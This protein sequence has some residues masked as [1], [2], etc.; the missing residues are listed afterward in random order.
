[1]GWEHGRHMK[2]S[3]IFLLNITCREWYLAVLCPLFSWISSKFW[4]FPVNSSFYRIHFRLQAPLLSKQHW[5]KPWVPEK[6]YWTEDNKEEKRKV[7]ALKSEPCLLF[8]KP[9]VESA[10]YLTPSGKARRRKVAPNSRLSSHSLSPSYLE[11]CP[12]NRPI[13]PQRQNSASL[14]ILSGAPW[15]H[16]G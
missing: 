16:R 15:R 7:L 2:E 13:L 12:M 8:K 9:W 6:I 3:K 4:L 11:P 1:M 5:P 14:P 10:P